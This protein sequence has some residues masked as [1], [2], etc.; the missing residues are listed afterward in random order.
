MNAVE[1]VALSFM[2]MGSCGGGGDTAADPSTTDIACSDYQLMIDVELDYGDSCVVDE[3][4]D[5]VIPDTGVGCDT[6]DVVVRYDYNASY[7]LGFIDDAEAA[8]C[9]VEF[10]TTGYCPIDGEPAC[11]YGRCGWE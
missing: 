5:Q 9:T 10:D 7:V 6:D 8:G 1:T 4:C 11:I 3:Q 2:L